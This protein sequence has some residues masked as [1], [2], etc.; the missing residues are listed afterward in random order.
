[1]FTTA[2]RPRT[3][4][5]LAGHPVHEDWRNHLKEPDQ[6]HDEKES[7]LAASADLSAQAWVSA[8]LLFAGLGQILYSVAPLTGVEAERLDLLI[9]WQAISLGGGLALGSP[10]AMVLFAGLLSPPTTERNSVMSHAR[11]FLRAQFALLLP[12]AISIAPFFTESWKE[13]VV[14]AVLLTLSLQVQVASALQR[15]MFSA[16]AKWRPLATQFSIDGLLRVSLT[17]WLVKSGA[18]PEVLMSAGIISQ[19]ASI[20]LSGPSEAKELFAG[21]QR[22]ARQFLSRY[23]SALA[24]S[25]GVQ[26]LLSAPP[27]LAAFRFGESD[28]TRFIVIVSQIV[29]IPMT[30]STPISLPALQRIGQLFAAGKPTLARPLVRRTSLAVSAAGVLVFV[31]LVSAGSEIADLH[32]RLQIL[33][34]ISLSSALPAAPVAIGLPVAAFLHQVTLFKESQKDTILW[35]VSLTI[36]YPVISAVIEPSKGSILVVPS[37]ISTLLCAAMWRTSRTD[38]N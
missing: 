30:L 12:I 1:M 29:R 31:T 34:E 7:K 6:H 32:P 38:R 10:A 3:S 37:V 23:L 26:I 9:A 2:I 19:V 20:V 35:L 5:N 21:S 22:T 28:E 13:A 27:A 33:A 24:A 15:S 14:F 17:T 4:R 11:W 8:G 36:A 16:S 18:A 25:G